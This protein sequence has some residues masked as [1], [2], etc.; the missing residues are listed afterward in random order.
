MATYPSSWMCQPNPG[1][2]VSEDLRESF[3]DFLVLP[4]HD[5]GCRWHAS[6]AW[7]L[8]PLLSISMADVAAVVPDGHL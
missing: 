7:S 3:G 8:S 1:R 4:G 5:L 6:S 2:R